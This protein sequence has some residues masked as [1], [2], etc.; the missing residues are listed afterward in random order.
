MDLAEI[1]AV[2]MGG[3]SSVRWIEVR[4]PGAVDVVLYA[5]H[6]DRIKSAR[7]GRC[8]YSCD[9]ISETYDV[10]PALGVESRCFEPARLR[11]ARWLT[12]RQRARG[13]TPR[14]GPPSRTARQTPPTIRERTKRCASG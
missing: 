10:L 9:D 12:P 8:C 2:S 13:F 7:T 6:S 3:S 5:T 11:P 1:G 4:A 14:K